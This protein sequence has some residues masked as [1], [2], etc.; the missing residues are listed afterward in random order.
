MKHSQHDDY[1]DHSDDF[2]ARVRA[3][4]EAAQRKMEEFGDPSEYEITVIHGHGPEEPLL[5][6]SID[7]SFLL[8]ETISTPKIEQL[9]HRQTTVELVESDFQPPV[10]EE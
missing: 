2:I 9:N 3:S 8:A 5:V 1:Y 4:K 6:A 7:E 10:V